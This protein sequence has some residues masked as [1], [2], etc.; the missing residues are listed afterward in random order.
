MVVM[1]AK[2]YEELSSIDRARWENALLR[3]TEAIWTKRRQF[4]ELESILIG[5][6]SA[7]GYQRALDFFEK[8]D[9][10]ALHRRVAACKYLSLQAA[11]YALDELADLSS[12]FANHLARNRESLLHTGF[13]ELGFHASSWFERQ[14][15]FLYPVKLPIAVQEGRPWHVQARA[16]AGAAKRDKG[17]NLIYSY[18]WVREPLRRLRKRLGNEEFEDFLRYNWDGSW[19]VDENNIRFTECRYDEAPIMVGLDE[20]D[21]ER[22]CE[23]RTRFLQ[24]QSCVLEKL[25]DCLKRRTKEGL[26]EGC[27]GILRNEFTAEEIDLFDRVDQFYRDSMTNVY[28]STIFVRSGLEPDRS[29]GL[30]GLFTVIGHVEEE[31][32]VG[33]YWKTKESVSDALPAQLHATDYY[34]S[35]DQPWQGSLDKALDGLVPLGKEV[36]AFWQ[37]FRKRVRGAIKKDFRV[38]LSITVWVKRGDREKHKPFV[39]TLADAAKSHLESGGQ[40]GIVDVTL[41]AASSAKSSKIQKEKRPE[42]ADIFRKLGKKWQVCFEGKTVYL[43]H[44]RGLAH[45]SFLLMYPKTQIDTLELQAGFA[46]D[47]DGQ[48]LL[49]PAAM[50]AADSKMVK[51]VKTRLAQIE[52]ALEVA[53]CTGD[54]DSQKTLQDEKNQLLDKMKSIMGL[55]GRTRTLSD[56][57]ETARL[58]V[59]KA[60]KRALD[61]IKKEHPEL[62][63]HLNKSL[64]LGHTVIY[65]PA[66]PVIWTT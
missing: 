53:R 3:L 52:E 41:E 11:S 7:L 14:L 30:S 6:E 8:T 55:G 4:I 21:A 22:L 62:H 25:E 38:P 29:N 51:N 18:T 54:E 43:D 31:L 49:R 56:V 35:A 50:K 42:P 15:G 46:R 9:V 13:P 64:R 26:W 40:P 1:L 27:L 45:I 28:L 34:Q 59:C 2:H 58:A 37:E 44:C 36:T 23:L 60:I 66:P 33:L 57:V 16:E 47:E 19:F 10:S 32:T 12:Y 17:H 20:H 39:K 24:V 5:A 48:S 63:R 65:T 61:Q